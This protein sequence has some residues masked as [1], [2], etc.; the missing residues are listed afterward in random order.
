LE[1]EEC[2]QEGGLGT[3]LHVSGIIFWVLAHQRGSPPPGIPPPIVLLLNRKGKMNNTPE[4][5]PVI[6][7]RVWGRKKHSMIFILQPLDLNDER[8]FAAQNLQ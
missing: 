1:I 7:M 8:E 6:L 2:H 5:E 3:F 4:G